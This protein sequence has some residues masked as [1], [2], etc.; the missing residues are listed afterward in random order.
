[1]G[2]QLIAN[3]EAMKNAKREAAQAEKGRLAEATHL[4]EKIVEVASLQEVL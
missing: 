4:K 3:V 2:H 1:M